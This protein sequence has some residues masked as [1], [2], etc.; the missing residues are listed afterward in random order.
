ML[1]IRDND[2]KRKKIFHCIFKVYLN[3]SNVS[4]YSNYKCIHTLV[5]YTVK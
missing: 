4:S 1:Y 2:E 5:D 3:Y